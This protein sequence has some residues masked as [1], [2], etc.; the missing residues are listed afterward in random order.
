MTTVTVIIPTYNAS[1]YITETVESI[2]NQDFQDFEIIIVDDCSIDS[3]VNIVKAI[4]SEKIRIITLDEN[5]GGPSRPRNIGIKNAKGKYIAFCDSDD[6]FVEGRIGNSVKFLNEETQLGMVFTN[7]KKFD[8]T[9]GKDLGN[10]LDGYK[11]FWAIKKERKN[12]DGYVISSIDAYNCLF[13]ENYIMPTGV[14]IPSDVF[15]DVG[16]FD[17]ELKNGDDRDMW[18]RITGCYPIGFINNIGFKY[19][20]RENSVSMRGP[21]LSLN[22]IKAIKKQ[23]RHGIENKLKYQCYKIIAENYFNI[24]YYYQKNLDFKKAILYYI[25]S[26]RYK[27]NIKAIKG[28]AITSI[29]EKAYSKI[30]KMKL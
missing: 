22:K 2:L 29:G 27:A 19:R 16:L 8:D 30:R 14:T 17:E 15:N 20:I 28:M 25:K 23:L 12:Q 26:N 21:Q 11:K 6:L 24:G 1:K 18:F 5:H 9:S 7:E 3:T 10:F 4:N 13:Y